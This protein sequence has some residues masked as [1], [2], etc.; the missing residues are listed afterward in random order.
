MPRTASKTAKPESVARRAARARAKEG[1]SRRAGRPAKPDA[2]QRTAAFA[3]KEILD[4]VDFAGIV[5]R[6][7][8]KRKRP[9][10]RAL[11][12]AA[13]ERETNWKRLLEQHERAIME[14][15][16]AYAKVEGEARAMAN[17]IG[18]LTA[19]GYHVKGLFAA[20]L[21]RY[22]GV[23]LDQQLFSLDQAHQFVARETAVMEAA[24]EGFGRN[25]AQME[26]QPDAEAE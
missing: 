13:V 15:A 19:Q 16:T 17:T 20:L 22:V 4:S 25:Q 6:A 5:E 26:R 14:S 7:T 3:A 11:L 18:V 8:A 21:Q 24:L 12:E 2:R 10:Y 1:R 23:K 9:N